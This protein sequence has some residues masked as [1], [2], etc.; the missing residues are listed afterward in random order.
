MIAFNIGFDPVIARI[1]AIE[2]GW[3][4]IF[5]ALAVVAGVWLALRLAE[6]RG[7]ATDLVANIAMWGV[8]GGV[9]G[10]RLFHVLDHLPTY[11]QDP[12]SVLAVWQ[13]GIAV[14]GAFL[15]GLAAGGIAA[16]RCR[17]DVW[18]LLD[19]AAPA[20]LVGQA[21]GRLGCLSNGDAWGANA[22]GCPLCLAVRYTNSNDLLPADLLGVPTYA[23]PIYEIVAVLLLL[24][25]LWLFR[26]RL[27]MRPGLT[28]V[29]MAFGYGVIRF[30]LSF[31]RQEAIVAG[32]LQEAQ[33]IALITS[34]LAALTVVWRV[35]SQR[36]AVAS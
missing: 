20:I 34:A 32:G 9:I 10:A 1:G 27:R 22:T 28:F 29:V 3:H 25:G 5:T 7:M 33:I 12:L 15:G 16:W 14:Y 2:L 13:G 26:E 35:R 11:L 30:A 23:Y 19:I 8:L 24:G 6:R 4:G 31:M 17:A 36:L 21:I 18:A